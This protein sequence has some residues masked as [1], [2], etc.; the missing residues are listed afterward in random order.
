MVLPF[1]GYKWVCSSYCVIVRVRIQ[2]AKKK[3]ERGV[4]LYLSSDLEF[5]RRRELNIS[6]DEIESRWIEAGR[7]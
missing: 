3:Q 2:W 6:S 1:N 5:T 7:A 4:G